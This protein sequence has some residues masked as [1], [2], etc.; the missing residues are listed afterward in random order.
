MVKTFERKLYRTCKILH[1]EVPAHLLSIISIYLATFSFKIL[2]NSFTLP[3]LCICHFHC[4][5]S[6]IHWTFLLKSTLCEEWLKSYTR[7]LPTRDLVS[8]LANPALIWR[9]LLLSLRCVPWPF[10]ARLTRPLLETLVQLSY[11]LQC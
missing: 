1:T 8:I 3:C 4:L 7:L 9:L 6:H 10:Q 5:E 2:S 11:T